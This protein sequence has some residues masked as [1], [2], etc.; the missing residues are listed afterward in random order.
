M[1]HA[2]DTVRGLMAEIDSQTSSN[3]T[4]SS[5]HLLA[6]PNA[7]IRGFIARTL[8]FVRWCQKQLANEYFMLS[9]KPGKVSIDPNL[10]K[11]AIMRY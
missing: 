1:V 8:L 11:A 3:A 10:Y 6:K 9:K 4:H 2:H 7:I 5:A